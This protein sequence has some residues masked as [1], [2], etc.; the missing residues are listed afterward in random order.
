[1]RLI[2]AGLRPPVFLT[3]DNPLVAANFW[4]ARLT[5][6]H[7]IAR[8]A[9]LLAWPAKL[10][11][12]YSYDQIPLVGWSRFDAWGHGT[13]LAALVGIA[14]MIAVAVRRRRTDRV[15]AFFIGFLL[16]TFLPTSN[17]ILLIG[18]IMAERFL[19]LPSVGFAACVAILV[20]RFAD[21]HVLA[22]GIIAALVL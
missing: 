20:W 14:G 13:A 16:L 8:Y 12:D 21:R 10:S 15:L 1:R 2:Y 7:V 22:I 5:A 3:V 19:Y 9:W 11:C 6:L 18:S 4:T 17:L